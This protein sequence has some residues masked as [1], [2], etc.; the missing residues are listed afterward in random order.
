MEF[1]KGYMDIAQYRHAL[2]DL[3][4]AIFGFSFETWYT[5]GYFEGEYIPY[6]YIE[7]GEIVSN[8]SVNI[9]KMVQNG[10]EKYYIQIGT[11]ATR[12]EY[13]NKSLAS[14]LIKKI[15]CDYESIADG[16][17]L[18]AN[19]H[20]VDFYMKQGFQRLDQW[21]Y[22]K[23]LLNE[24]NIADPFEKAGENLQE[25]YRHLLRNGKLNT[26]LDQCNKA[27]L[28]LFYTGKMEDVYYHSGL[29][30]FA[31]MHKQEMVLHLDSIISAAK[32]PITEILKRVPLEYDTV[33]LG[34]TP[35][36]EDAIEFTAQQ[37]DGEDNYRFCYMGA[38][39]KEI[40]DDRLY[41]PVMTHA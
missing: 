37:F 39:L 40:A 9:M 16:F 10:Q 23:K 7:N 13:R 6:S 17:Y 1:I 20:A 35:E 5:A 24:Q 30:C 41:F 8:A 29:D 11:V 32:I 31:V 27:A 38:S 22:S 26:K 36:A 3:T 12:P 33:V 25:R 18:F 21:Q 15:I 2:N 14:N 4:Q 34:F 28:Q 19:I